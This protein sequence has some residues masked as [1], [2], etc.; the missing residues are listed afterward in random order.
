MAS[1]V[2]NDR[3]LSRATPAA[4]VGP[5]KGSVLIDGV[6]GAI[7]HC[8]HDKKASRATA[9]VEHVLPLGPA[10]A[11]SVEEAALHT[12]RFWREGAADH[13]VRLVPIVGG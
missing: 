4:A 10:A 5:Y 9:V 8:E 7:W 1:E 13:D 11:S 6:V 3:A 2:L 12:I